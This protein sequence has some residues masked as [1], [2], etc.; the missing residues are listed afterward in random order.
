M[1]DLIKQKIEYLLYLLKYEQDEQH[2]QDEQDEESEEP[3]NKNNNLSTLVETAIEVIKDNNKNKVTEYNLK[4]GLNEIQDKVNEL[5]SRDAPLTDNQY[6]ILADEN[7]KILNNIQPNEEIKEEYDEIMTKINT[8]SKLTSLKSSN[9]STI[10]QT[11]LDVIIYNKSNMTNAEISETIKEQYLKIS[12]RIKL[13]INKVRNLKK[14]TLL[15]ITA[16]N[17][18]QIIKTAIDI[19]TQSTPLNISN[20]R[21]L[22]KTAVELLSHSNE[23][24]VNGNNISPLVKTSVDLLV[25]NVTK[26]NINDIHFMEKQLYINMDNEVSSILKNIKTNYDV[27]TNFITPSIKKNETNSHLSNGLVADKNNFDDDN[28]PKIL[29]GRCNE[30]TNID[31]T[32]KNRI[33]QQLRREFDNLINESWSKIEILEKDINDIINKNL[34]LKNN[35]SSFIKEAENQQA[36]IDNKIK[37]NNLLFDNNL[38]EIEKFTNDIKNR[39]NQIQ[40]GEQRIET[41]R[42]SIS[43]TGTSDAVRLKML[44]NSLQQ[45]QEINKKLENDL[46]ELNNDKELLE[47][48]NIMLIEENDKLKEENKT[49]EDIIKEKQDENI[50]ENKKLLE[51]NQNLIDKLKNVNDLNEMYRINMG[52][53]INNKLEEIEEIENLKKLNAKVDDVDNKDKQLLQLTNNIFNMIRKSDINPEDLY[54]LLPNIGNFND[55]LSKIKENVECPT[56]QNLI[57]KI[58]NDCLYFNDENKIDVITEDYD[59]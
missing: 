20:E 4:K 8:L 43:E 1:D 53:L 33:I 40:I 24:T 29:S 10:V 54:I 13:L 9:V 39:E 28:C 38:K 46:I 51:E 3:K 49:F 47:N 15:D 26:E 21:P 37:E 16:N 36:I 12:N 30:P 17:N 5:Y 6:S 34:T 31:I 7:M 18:K 45:K 56:T 57:G 11:A 42:K 22:V 55:I 41:I 52:K 25:R 35:I 23:P 44:Q 14:Q 19:L 32:D 27:L 50:E 59:K 48:N 58:N 2:E